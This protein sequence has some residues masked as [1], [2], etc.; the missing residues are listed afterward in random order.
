MNGSLGR[1]FQ[2]EVLVD[3]VALIHNLAAVPL[4]VRFHVSVEPLGRTGK[5]PVGLAPNL[6]SVKQRLRAGVDPLSLFTAFFEELQAQIV[7]TLVLVDYLPHGGGHFQT[8]PLV[9][10]V[11]GDQPS[12][13]ALHSFLCLEL[14][15]QVLVLLRFGEVAVKLNDPYTVGSEQGLIADGGKI[16]TGKPKGELRQE[17]RGSLIEVPS[18]DF[19][20]ACELLD[21]FFVQL[22]ILVALCHRD[23][24]LAFQGS[25]HGVRCFGVLRA[26][27][28]ADDRHG[29]HGRIVTE[30]VVN[31]R[32]H[33]G[34]T[35]ASGLAMENEHTFLVR[36]TQHGVPQ[37]L[38]KIAQFSK[39]TIPKA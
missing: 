35:V 2:S 21:C 31:C 30:K 15:F 33:G 26:L 20:A 36:H 24:P 6:V 12:E 28:L 1:S 29:G 5:V 27:R 9:L 10:E 11:S 16:V 13:N 32:E 3:G 39:R 18:L 14:I 38:L 17:G 22:A 19:L 34:L 7:V 4:R 23:E 8:E 37:R 25:Q